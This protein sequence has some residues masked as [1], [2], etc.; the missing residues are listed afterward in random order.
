VNVVAGR[1]GIA[2]ISI[3]KGE[4][5]Y[6][7][8]AIHAPDIHRLYV[9]PSWDVGKVK[10]IPSSYITTFLSG[11]ESNADI[12]FEIDEEATVLTLSIVAGNSVIRT[13]KIPLMSV[14]MVYEYPSI[15]DANIVVVVNEFKKFCSTISKESSEIR[16]E[17]QDECI[18]FGTDKGDVFTYGMFDETKPFTVSHVSSLGFAKA[19][20]INIGNT[21]SAYASVAVREEYP[22]LVRLKLGMVE[23][24]IF[25]NRYLT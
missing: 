2:F 21:K 14:D 1:C 17:V 10:V 13:K 19:A 12:K 7:I 11:R 18:R 4:E 22:M 20:Q 3:P 23:F 5:C 15:T 25:S 6:Y 8:A 24:K 16:L 9:S